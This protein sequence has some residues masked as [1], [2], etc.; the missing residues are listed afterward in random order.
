MAPFF[1]A[2]WSQIT[3]WSI[4]SCLL[5]GLAG[6]GAG[7]L[8]IPSHDSTNDPMLICNEER[9]F[10]STYRLIQTIEKQG[11]ESGLVT[12]HVRYADES[13]STLEVPIV[14]LGQ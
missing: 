2:T 10:L 7:Q 11:Q 13:R 4:G 8:F 5:A 1:K 12:F 14:Y 6:I 3:L 9:L